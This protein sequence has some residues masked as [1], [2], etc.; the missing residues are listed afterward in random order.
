LLET[1]AIGALP[2][3]RLVDEPTGDV[4]RLVNV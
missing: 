4:Y 2:R 1:G 3:T